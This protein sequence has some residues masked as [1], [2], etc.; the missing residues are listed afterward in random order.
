[1]AKNG[2]KRDDRGLNVKIEEGSEEAKRGGVYVNNYQ[3]KSKSG[4]SKSA[5]KKPASFSR[6]PA[7]KT[8]KVTAKD[9]TTKNE[10]TKKKETTKKKTKVEAPKKEV[11]KETKKEVPKVKEEIKEEIKKENITDKKSEIKEEKVVKKDTP[12]EEKIVKEEPKEVTDSFKEFETLKIDTEDILKSKVI[13]RDVA[14]DKLVEETVE[15][16]VAAAQKDEVVSPVVVMPEPK[17]DIARVNKR[18]QTRAE[19]YTETPKPRPKIT[20]S[21]IK[22][23]EIEKAVSRASKLPEASK[24]TRRRKDSFF[25]EFG[26]QR[27]IL[28]VACAATAVFA[29]A[30]L[31][32]ITSTDISL[33]VAAMQSGIEASYPSYVPRGY[34]L[35]DVTSSSGRVTMNFK[36]DGGSFSLSEESSTWD[37]SALLNNYVKDYHED[38]YAIIR[39]QGL[40][41]YM[42]GNWEAWVN[43]GILYKLTVTSGS[44][45]KKQMK[46]I[47]TSL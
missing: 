20:S 37:S 22:T 7:K 35:S 19:V 33:K 32:N 5:T 3:K 25:H 47:A 11:K 42:G 26:W 6:S 36:T 1:M 45:T 17:V 2:K 24:H 27:M 34:S 39:E 4:K 15:E 16:I 43:G 8:E 40:T 10:S 14:E 38:D 18:M 13:I 12:V 9:S 23:R 29:I 44:L 28:A 41:L 31:I 46:S 21:E 30:Y